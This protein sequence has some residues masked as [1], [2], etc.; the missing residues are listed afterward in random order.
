M[1]ALQK[2]FIVNGD[3]NTTIYL[4]YGKTDYNEKTDYDWVRKKLN[5]EYEIVND[6]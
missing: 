6:D 4:K 2:K 1:Q 5:I 3:V